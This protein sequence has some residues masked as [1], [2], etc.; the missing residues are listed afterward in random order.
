MINTTVIELASY[1]EPIIVKGV[2]QLDDLITE[3]ESKQ[4]KR[5][6]KEFKVWK[7]DINLVISAVNQIAG[8][9]RCRLKK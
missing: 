8:F 2:V 4:P 3:L 5:S 6:T 7:K 9:S 1:P